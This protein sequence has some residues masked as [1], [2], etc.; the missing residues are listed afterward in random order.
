MMV[1]E[2]MQG[3]KTGAGE[4]VEHGCRQMSDVIVGPKERIDVNGYFAEGSHGGRTTRDVKG[5]KQSEFMVTKFPE[6]EGRYG[7]SRT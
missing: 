4:G 1:T 3:M 6:C 2:K 7:V 5:H